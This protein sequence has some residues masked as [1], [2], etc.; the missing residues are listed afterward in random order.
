MLLLKLLSFFVKG[1]VFI[2]EY[3]NNRV[4]KVTVSTGIITNMAG[5]S[6]SAGYG[7]DGGQAT[8]ALL[9]YATAVTL[10]TSG[11]YSLICIFVLT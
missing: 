7:G 8:S 9:Y 6:T 5:S 2:T 4:R 11:T 10:D 1:N 3:V